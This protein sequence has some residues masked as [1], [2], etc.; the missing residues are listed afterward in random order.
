MREVTVLTSNTVE[1]E[2]DVGT[3]KGATN[4]LLTDGAHAWNT[5]RGMVIAIMLLP[6]FICLSGVLAALMGKE[7]YKWFIGEDRFAENIQVILWIISF[8][9]SFNVARSQV[10]KGDYLF[11]A[12]YVL[13]CGGIFFII[14]EELSWGQRILGWTTPESLKMMNKQNE[15]NIHNIYEIGETIKWIHLM[16]GAYGTF[17]PFIVLGVKSL[18]RYQK[19]VSLLVPHLT[20]LPYFF[21]PFVWRVYRN[22]FEDPQRYRF[23]IQEYSEVI[24]LVIAS[25]FMFFLLYQNRQIKKMSDDNSN[26]SS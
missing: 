15:T 8:V 4:Y 3:N 19:E 14:G 16:V 2:V 17:A 21:I 12:L 24:E 20:L 11:G 13:L 1:R 18:Q 5:S 26:G 23:V 25:A 6:F 22:F 7:A 9:F 10:R